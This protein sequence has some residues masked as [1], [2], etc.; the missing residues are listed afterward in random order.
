MRLYSKGIHLDKIEEVKTRWCWH[1]CNKN[2]ITSPQTYINP[3][4]SRIIGCSLSEDSSSQIVQPS[5]GIYKALDQ[6]T[7][8]LP[9]YFLNLNNDRYIDAFLMNFWDQPCNGCRLVCKLFWFLNT[10]LDGFRR[11][12]DSRHIA[13]REID[14]GSRPPIFQSR[15]IVRPCSLIFFVVPPCAETKP[16]RKMSLIP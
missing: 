11:W 7:K 6:K 16:L 3:S 10:Y 13:Y 1:M 12:G 9:F 4:I 14:S 2:E 8:Y 5:G 15:E